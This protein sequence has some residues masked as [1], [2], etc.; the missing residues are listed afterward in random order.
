MGRRFII[1]LGAVALLGAGAR[2]MARPEQPDSARQGRA[3]YAQ[4]CLGCHARWPARPG[5]P[6]MGRFPPAGTL[7]LQQRYQNA[8]PSAL[9]DRHDL[10]PDMV[11]MTV[12]NGI[13]IMPPTRK[14]EVSDAQLDALVIYLTGR[15]GG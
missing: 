15:K 7:R 2:G 5:D 13:T 1:V 6:P 12:R 14:S 10:A 11:R 3:V 4:W 9:E 8:M